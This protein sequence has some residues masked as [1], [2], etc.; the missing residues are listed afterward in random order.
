MQKICSQTN[1]ATV[2]NSVVECEKLINSNCIIHEA[3]IAYLS[4]PENS[5]MTEVV[6]AL[7]LSLMD[8][9][10]TITLLDNRVT[11]LETP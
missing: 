8:A 4:L 1:V 2:D 10:N 6:N 11:I 3:A 9:R 7:L 5:S